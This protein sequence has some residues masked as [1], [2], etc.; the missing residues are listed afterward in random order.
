[1]TRFAY[2]DQLASMPAVVAEIIARTEWPRLDMGRPILFAGIGTSLHAARVAA[3]WVTQ[4]TSG[5]V[6]A[7]GVDAHDLGDMLTA[8]LEGQAGA[9][10]L[11]MR[12][13]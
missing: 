5:K 4:L 8:N 7:L 12:A 10:I 6:R 1:M 13:K 9:I 11:P 2:D 3:D